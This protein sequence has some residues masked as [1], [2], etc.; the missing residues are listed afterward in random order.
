VGDAFDSALA[1]TTIGLYKTEC[2]LDSSPFRK[3]PLVTLACLEEI[4]AAWVHWDNTSRLMHRLD[5]KPPA[6]YC[7]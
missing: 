5:L 1:E 6:R 4:T 3:G 2:I 7:H